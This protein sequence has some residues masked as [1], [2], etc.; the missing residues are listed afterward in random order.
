MLTPFTA[1]GGVDF[2]AL[3][4]LTNRYLDAG[5]G[6][7]FANCLSS[8]MYDLSEAE[9]LAVISHVVKLAAGRVPV[10]ATG[11]FGETISQQAIF[12]RKVHETGVN[13]VI[14]I[15][16]LIA[17][18]VESDEVFEQRVKELMDLTPGIP[19]GFY[20]CPIPYKRLVKPELLGRFASTGR[21]T[22]HKDTSLN[23]VQVRE[24]LAL[25]QHTQLNLYDAYMGHTVE[26][27]KA[28]SAGVSCIQGNFFPKLVVWLCRNYNA[29]DRKEDVA[30][31]QKFLFDNLD[32]MHI[33]YP[34]TVKYYLMKK[35]IINSSYSRI[36]KEELTD[37]VRGN[38]D[39]LVEDYE[40]LAV[41]LGL[42]Q[43]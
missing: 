41:K 2:D 22:Y 1:E 16:S 7:L 24:K 3:T 37:E 5:T 34:K 9:K 42:N 38:I 39:K 4:T 33:R 31:V 29:E 30:I 43:C 19:L 18:Q 27:L 8:E 21:F 12:V 6:G 17:T 25:T 40:Q 35:G 32:V 11:N 13:A 26:S 15:S 20:E 14:I 10:V 23:I 28:G 36:E